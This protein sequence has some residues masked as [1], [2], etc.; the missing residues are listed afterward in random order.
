MQQIK[1]FFGVDA[2]YKF[3]YLLGW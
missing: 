1:R 2:L 3:A